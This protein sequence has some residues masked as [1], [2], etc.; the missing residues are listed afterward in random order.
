MVFKVYKCLCIHGDG[1]YTF[2]KIKFSYNLKLLT[3]NINQKKKKL[4]RIL[5]FI[6]LILF[7]FRK[8]KQTSGARGQKRLLPWICRFGPDPA[9]HYILTPTQSHSN[10]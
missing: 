6:V 3:E 10:T 1:I 2:I 7:S 4:Q 9:L 8:V 5:I